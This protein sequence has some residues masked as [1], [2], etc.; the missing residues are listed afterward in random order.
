IFHHCCLK[1]PIVKCD[2]IGLNKFNLVT[3]V[4]ESVQ[5]PLLKFLR[6]LGDNINQWI[7]LLAKIDMPH[8]KTLQIWGTKLV[9]QDLSH[10]SVLCVERLISMRSL[11]E[12][13]FKD[14]LLQ[15]QHDWVHIVDKMHPSMLDGFGLEGSSYEQFMA[16]PDAVDLKHLRKTEWVVQLFYSQK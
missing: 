13:H 1:K 2:L 14:V 15:D 4:L 16:T 8:L 7:Q 10:V 9:Q 3:N 12:Q 6:L 5:W 11:S